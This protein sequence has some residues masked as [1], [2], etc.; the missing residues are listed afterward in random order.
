MG[1]GHVVVNCFQEENLQPIMKKLEHP[2]G[3][4]GTPDRM[5]LRLGQN[6]ST[7]L[8]GNEERKRLP[9]LVVW[10]GVGG[11]GVVGI[12]PLHVTRLYCL[13]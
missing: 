10:P 2:L 3:G 4:V 7:Q 9:H 5:E 8:P 1:N 13:K 12:G 6:T 11:R